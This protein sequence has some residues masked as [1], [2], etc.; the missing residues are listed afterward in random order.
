MGTEVVRGLVS[1]GRPQK[2]LAFLGQ[3]SGVKAG[4]PTDAS[5]F[6][7][8]II[9]FFCGQAY[10]QGHFRTGHSMLMFGPGFL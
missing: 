2:W 6:F 5:Y 10:P 8:F 7:Q 9:H 1:R 3:G 4:A